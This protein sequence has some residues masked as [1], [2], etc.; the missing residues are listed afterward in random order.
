[1]SIEINEITELN[2]QESLARFGNNKNIYTR[3]LGIFATKYINIRNS[4]TKC[5]SENDDENYTIEIH[6]LKGALANI[7]ANEL[8][9]TAHKFEMLSKDGG[10]E[11]CKDGTITLLGDVDALVEK[12][13]Q[14]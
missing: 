10:F 2:V 9:E 14:L 1:M 8:S 3:M 4:L 13:K 6:G 7:G 5:I 12:L 11:S